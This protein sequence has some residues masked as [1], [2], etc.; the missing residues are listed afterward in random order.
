MFGPALARVYQIV[1][2][3]NLRLGRNVFIDKHTKLCGQNFINDN[4][5]VISTKLG[6]YSY[7]SPNSIIIRANV[8]NYCSI[9][10][11]CIIGTGK[12][13]LDECSTSPFVYNQ[14]L[15]SGRNKN[16]FDEVE[17]GHDVWIGAN[18][19]IIGGVKIGNGAV[20]GANSLITRDIEPYAIAFGSPA[21]VQRYRFKL[22]K[23]EKLTERK[24]W[25]LR[26]DEAR[27]FFDEFE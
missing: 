5:R 22:E 16:D 10:P 21:I 13:P 1:K 17:I 26:P 25:E 15:F 7:I 27:K 20:I 24:W 8:G 11:N 2:S 12:H 19:T 23:I 14:K 18:V 4:A 6:R 9:G 3:E